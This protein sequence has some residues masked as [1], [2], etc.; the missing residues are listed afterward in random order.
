MTA[1]LQILIVALG[2]GGDVYPMID[3]GRWMAARGHRVEFVSSPQ[4]APSV[5]ASD[6]AFHPCVSLPANLNGTQDAGL[7]QGNSAYRALFD[8]LLRAV[9][10]A[11]RIITALYEPGRTVIVANAAA[12]GARIARET[13][14]APLVTVHFQPILLRSR[15]H[16]PGLI[17]SRKWRPLV[18]AMRAV[19]MPALDRWVFD[20]ALAPGL[21]EFRGRLGLPPVKR[22]FGGWIHSPDLVLGLFP[23][24]FATPEPDWPPHTHLVGFPPTDLVFTPGEDPPLDAFLDSGSPP[25]VF[26][27]SSIPPFAGRFFETS[28]EAC[29]MTGRRALLVTQ[30]GERLPWLPSH[31]HH[32][33]DTPVGHVLARAAALVHH[34]GVNTMGAAFAAGIPQIAV[35]LTFDQPDN[36][37]R[38]RALG[39][40][41]V[42][43]PAAYFADTVSRTLNQVLTSASILTTCR[44]IA[45]RVRTA[46]PMRRACE[47]IERAGAKSMGQVVETH[48]S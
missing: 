20:P 5:R 28:I 31:V 22:V 34:G 41:A 48:A 8:A 43:R 35:P 3:I 36:A 18:R 15:N 33:T 39:A 6:L 12:M 7:A 1:R 13:L 19:L 37:A 32:V 42:V 26:S 9:P 47:L 27:S 17:V 14:D 30:A 4:F 45:A 44:T 24:W 11:Y 21:N 38:L 25:V 46:E 23:D 40:G 2:S 10:A 16:Q 29:R